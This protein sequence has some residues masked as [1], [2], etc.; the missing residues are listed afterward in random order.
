MN[1]WRLKREKRRHVSVSMPAGWRLTESGFRESGN[2]RQPTVTEEMRLLA[3]VF[4]LRYDGNA[5]G[6]QITVELCDFERSTEV[7]IGG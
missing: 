5:Y 4:V 6:K 3:E 1:M 2:G 7:C